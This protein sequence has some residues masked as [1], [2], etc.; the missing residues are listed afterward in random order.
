MRRLT[1]CPSRRRRIPSL[2][3]PDGAS[4]ERR[5][6]P[7][8]SAPLLPH[9]TALGLRRIDTRTQPRWHLTFRLIQPPFLSTSVVGAIST[10]SGPASPRQRGL[11]RTSWWRWT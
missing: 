10:T 9:D 3:R 5:R 11:E 8:P 2:A 4:L 7:P 6:W 1:S